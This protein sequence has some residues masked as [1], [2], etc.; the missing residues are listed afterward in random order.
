MSTP[1]I[2][3]VRLL[4]I[5]VLMAT[6]AAAAGCASMQ[7]FAQQQEAYNRS[8]CQEFGLTPGSNAYVQCISQGADAYANSLKNSSP[9]PP[10]GVPV[11]PILPFWPGQQQ[12]NACSAPVSQPKGGCQGCSV[13]CCAQQASCTPGQEWLGGSE[14]CMSPAVCVCK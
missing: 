13:S 5:A 2:A 6:A 8:K 3:T 10:A 4:L 11:V 14:T 9:P 12:N 7:N 1:E